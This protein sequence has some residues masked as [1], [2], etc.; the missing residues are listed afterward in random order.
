MLYTGTPGSPILDGNDI[1][2]DSSS[3]IKTTIL[4]IIDGHFN[5][6]LDFPYMNGGG[7]SFGDNSYSFQDLLIMLRRRFFSSI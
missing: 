4:D 1:I 6:N 3:D 5:E 7:M 2:S